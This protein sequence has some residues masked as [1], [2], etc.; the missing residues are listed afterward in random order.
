MT[1]ARFDINILE[2]K[3][4]AENSVP[5][6]LTLC[7]VCGHPLRETKEGILWCPMGDW[8]SDKRI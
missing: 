4:N 3:R 1:E 7:P 5:E 6:K 8:Q 2:W